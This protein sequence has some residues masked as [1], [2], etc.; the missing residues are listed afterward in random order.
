VQP[1]GRLSVID[2]VGVS[3]AAVQPNGKQRGR[4]LL[5]TIGHTLSPLGMASPLAPHAPTQNATK[6]IGY[7]LKR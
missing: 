7:I 4:H 5:V 1:D 3:Q 2:C 6:L